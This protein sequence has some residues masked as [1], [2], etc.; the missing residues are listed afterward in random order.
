MLTQEYGLIGIEDLDVKG[1]MSDHHLARSIADMS[2]FEFRRQLEYKAADSGTRIIVADRW[3]PSSKLCHVC[4]SINE[5]LTLG[6]REWDCGFCGTHH[7]R[8]HNAAINLKNHAILI[9]GDKN[10]P[11]VTR[12]QPV[13]SSSVGNSVKQEL[14][15]KP[16]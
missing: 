8:D 2:F 15:I 16:A 1:M 7:L 12:F 11:G 4:G 5:G 6:E 13:E 9:A 3:F 14:S 10:T